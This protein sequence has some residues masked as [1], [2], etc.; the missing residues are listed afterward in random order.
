MAQHTTLR[1]RCWLWGQAP[2]S[3]YLWLQQESRITPREAARYLNIPNMMLVVMGNQPAPA[4]FPA[5][6]ADNDDLPRVVWSIMGDAS[7]HRNDTESDLDAVLALAAVH[8][9]ITGAIMDDLFIFP[10]NM[11][12]SGR[13]AR[14]TAEQ[15]AQARTTLCAAIR[16]LDLYAVFYSELLLSEPDYLEQAARH[17]AACDQVTFWT[18]EARNLALLEDHFT[19]LEAMTGPSVG[20]LLGLYLWDYG[21]GSGPIPVEL[22]ARQC[23]IACAWLREGRIE[24]M[25]F[26]GSPV[27]DLGLEA[28]EW[29]RDWL[30]RVGDEVLPG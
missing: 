26:V 17:L 1:D 19:R 5:W 22:M 16:P 23:E 29:T 11:T 30:A 10:G 3:H 20:K 21:G 13:V 27:C 24:G 7:S 14:W 9:N 2:N 8:P 28:V 25:V 6:Q 15:I 4:E 18:W 12:E